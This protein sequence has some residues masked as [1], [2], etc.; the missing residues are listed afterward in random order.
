M[1][2]QHELELRDGQIVTLDLDG[3]AGL[4]VELRDGTM[5][6]LTLTEAEAS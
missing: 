4:A 2:G 3:S 5:L 1:E 6:S